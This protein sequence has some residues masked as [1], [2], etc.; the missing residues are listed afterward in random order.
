[1]LV[2]MRYNITEASKCEIKWLA[3]K[4]RYIQLANPTSHVFL[5]NHIKDCNKE[6][7]NHGPR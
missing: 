2:V 6:Q 3:T 5:D 1:M 7:S 4:L